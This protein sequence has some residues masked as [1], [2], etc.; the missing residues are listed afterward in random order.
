M[1]RERSR[2]AGHVVHD[3]V[4]EPRFEPEPRHRGRSFHYRPQLLCRSS[5]RGTSIPTRGAPRTGA[6]QRQSSRG[7]RRGA[8]TTT[9]VSSSRRVASAASRSRNSAR[10]RRV[11]ALRHAF[12]EL[13]DEHDAERSALARGERA[14][15]RA[16]RPDGRRASTTTLVHT[17]RQATGR[18]GRQQARA[19]QRR[20]AAPRCPDDRARTDV[21]ASRPSSVPISSS[22]PKNN[23]ASSARNATRP[24]NGN[25]TESVRSGSSP[26][27][28]RRTASTICP[29][30]PRVTACTASTSM[31]TPAAIV[32]TAPTPSGARSMR[33]TSPRCSSLSSTTASAGQN[34]AVVVGTER[35]DQRQ[36]AQ[37]GA[38]RSSR[39]LRGPAPTPG[40]GRRRR[41]PAGS[42][43]RCERT[44]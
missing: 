18:K 16:R 32:A 9:R 33:S 35:A 15:H 10:L 23:A 40:A 2:F 36:P 12:F 34:R 5:A 7:G 38:R 44:C 3:D 30:F 19:D 4:H 22:R 42:R 37:V 27:A 21:R 8:V 24:L 6:T 31:S 14:R 25:A 1:Q 39:T 41:V 13:V 11:G 26:T 17:S 28:R 20:L 29:G 43:W